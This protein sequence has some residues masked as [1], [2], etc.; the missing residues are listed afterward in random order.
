MGIKKQDQARQRRAAKVEYRVN[1]IGAYGLLVEDEQFLSTPILHV[2]G[3]GDL[4]YHVINPRFIAN[5]CMALHYP[6]FSKMVYFG[7]YS[8]MIIYRVNDD[9]SLRPV[10]SWK[11][12]EAWREFECWKHD[13]CTLYYVGGLF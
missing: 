10:L 6:S 8:G 4:A 12:T 11:N 13:D 9:G 7:N 5:L 2:N 1:C 3:P